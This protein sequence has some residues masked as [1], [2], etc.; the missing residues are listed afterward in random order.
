MLAPQA[1]DLSTDWF[2]LTD[3]ETY[4]FRNGGFRIKLRSW[5]YYKDIFDPDEWRVTI[6]DY[7]LRYGGGTETY[8]GVSR[9]NILTYMTKVIAN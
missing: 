2:H 3:Q 8:E 7:L 6:V 9:E 1:D 5:V 4:E